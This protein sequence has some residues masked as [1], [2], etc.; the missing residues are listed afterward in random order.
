MKSTDNSE[1]NSQLYMSSG[2]AASMLGVNVTT[3]YSYV[4]RKR[5]RTTQV[6][7]SRERYYWRADI[8]RV[9]SNKG[10]RIENSSKLDTTDLTLLTPEGHYYRG[11]NA[12]E[13]ADSYSLEKVASLLW[14]V[15]EE[16]AFANTLPYVPPELQSMGGLLARATSTDKAIALLPFLEQANPRAFDLSHGGMC[17]TGADVLRWYAAIL[18]DAD[19]PSS[20][21]LHLQ[22]ARHLKVSDDV[23]DAIR[24]LLVLSADHGFGAGT[25]AVRAVASTGVTAYRSVL[26]GLIITSGRRSRLGQTESIWHFVREIG[27]CDDPRS[28]IV[29]R[30][31]DGERVPGFDLPQPYVDADPR[32]LSMMGHIERIYGEHP[33]FIKVQR[34]AEVVKDTLDLSPSFAAVNVLFGQ[35][36]GLEAHR[37]LYVLGRCAGWV[38]HSIEQV[39]ISDAIVPPNRYGGELPPL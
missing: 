4:S 11:K 19:C 14:R 27:E 28:V 15:D 13:L 36:A 18:T 31:R 20:V 22:V 21:P 26:A 2:E 39:L 8:E 38:A 33:L 1:I 23:A 3:L 37:V 29:R 9:A 6:P 10:K 17:R 12:I 25:H 32:A 30:L 35:L 5:L 34:A 7:G 16:Y 24:R